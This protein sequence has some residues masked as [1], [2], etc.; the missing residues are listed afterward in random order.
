LGRSQ[1]G[2]ETVSKALAIDGSRAENWQTKLADQP[3]VRRRAATSDRLVPSSRGD[4]WMLVKAVRATSIA[5]VSIAST[6]SVTMSLRAQTREP[7]IDVHMHALAAN[8]QGPPPLGMCT[9]IDPFPAWDQRLPYGAAFQALFKKPPC[10]NPVWSPSTDEELML[11]TIAA[12][13][14]LNVIG[15]LSGLPERVD[16]WMKAAGHRF[17]PAVQLSLGRTGEP[18]IEDLRARHRDGRLRVLG[19]IGTQYN[20]IAPDDQR[21]E[22]YWRLAEELDLPVGI[23]IGPGPPGVIYLGASGYRAR[24]HSALTIE[25]VLVRHPKIRLYVMHAGF[26]LLDDMLAVLYAHPQV[27]VDTGVI[28]YT[29]PR[30]GFY[31]YLQG[32]VEAGFGN[33]VMF[34][35]DQMVWPGVIERSIAVIE[36]APFL[37]AGQKRDILYNNAAR[38][39]RLDE[40]KS[41]AK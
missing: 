10:A 32:L 29:Q 5:A 17:I 19:E 38:F 40:T 28:V 12:A 14:R 33:R 9:P 26:P 22:P 2:E 20:G 3:A 4:A 24:L 31:R 25:E 36:D 1:A 6:L 21:L 18:T 15:V 23:H 39:L 30:A 16:L 8:A 7:V 34:G 13:E 27:Y 11:Q 37:S 35:S 41:G